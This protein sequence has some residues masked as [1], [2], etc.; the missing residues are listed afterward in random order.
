MK[1]GAIFDMD[2]LLLDTERLY[3]KSM[4]ETTRRFGVPHTQAFEDALAGT[5]DAQGMAVIR[6]F[7][8]TVDAPAM[9]EDC[10]ARVRRWLERDVPL[11][12]GARELPLY[13]REHGVRTAVASSTEKALVLRSLRLAGL[14][15]SFDAVVSGQ[16]V[17]HG[18]PAPDIFLRAAELIGCAPEDCF[19]FEDSISGCRAGIAAGCATVMV[20]NLFQPTED[21]RAGCVGIFRSLLEVQ[22]ALERGKLS[23]HV[24]GTP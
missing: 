18:K 24:P 12:P 11:K 21:V 16:E 7:Y 20:I 13:F 4:E 5:N 19:V 15:G 23:Q 2:G 17:A 10:T 3:Y 1:Q 9:L 8:P 14:D 6:H 22:Q